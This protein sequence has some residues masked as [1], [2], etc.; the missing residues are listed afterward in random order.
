MRRPRRPGRC[1]PCEELEPTL[2]F[3]PRTC[4]LLTNDGVH[5]LPHGWWIRA[6]F[7]SSGSHLPIDEPLRARAAAVPARALPTGGLVRY[8][9]RQG[10]SGVG[11]AHSALAV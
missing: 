4:C 5:T 7:G 11:A 1:L 3:E 6:G 8:S 9:V 2:G 10:R